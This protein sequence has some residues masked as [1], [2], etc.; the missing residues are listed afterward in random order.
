MDGLCEIVLYPLQ[1]DHR[2][3]FNAEPSHD[4][5]SSSSVCL[6]RLMIP[7]SLDHLLT[8][9]I[10]GAECGSDHEFLIAK[11]RLKVKKVGKTTRPFKYAL[12]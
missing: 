12:N 2:V 7:W 10:P 6:R 11:F 8:K 1:S 3:I 5:P 4:Q 9:T